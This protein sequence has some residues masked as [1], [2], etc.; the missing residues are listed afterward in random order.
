MT[1]ELQQLEHSIEYTFRNKGLLEQALTH[2]SYTGE[3]PEV[4][5]YQ[6]LE[7]LG[8]AVI[9]MTVGEFLYRTSSRMDEG[10]LSQS[11]AKIVSEKP[12][13]ITAKAVDLGRYVRMSTGERNSGGAEK[14]SI[15]SDVFEAVMAAVY[16]DGGFDE[17]KR[18]ILALLQPRIKSVLEGV[19]GSDDK[20]RLQELLQHR[21][22]EV[23]IEYNCLE[24]S[25]PAHD[26]TFVSEVCVNWEALGKGEGKSKKLSEQMAA[27]SAL[28][29]LTA[30]GEC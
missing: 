23:K 10:Q 9:G 27:R 18:V 4:G 16:L 14:P 5:H 15:L 19:G 1:A 20:S 8:D 29:K 26:R 21:S 7:F 13:F 22:G 11:R 17:A 28:E 2:P 12:L 24:S 25:G 3:H 6:R 30:K